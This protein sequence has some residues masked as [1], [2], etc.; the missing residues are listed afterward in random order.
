[1]KIHHAIADGIAATHMLAGL[2]DN[3]EGNT[4]ANQI[5]AAKEPATRLRLP[6]ITLN[7]INWIAGAWRTSL[8]LGS[9]AAQALHG[10]IEIVGGLLRPAATSSLTGPVTS[11]R[12]YASAE[13]SLEDVMRVCEKFDVTIND[14]ALAAITDSFRAML[15]RRG[16]QPKANS[17][18]T[19]VPVSVRSNDA[20]DE[21]D[22][23]VSAMLP[24]LPVEKADPLEQLRTVHRRL[25]RTKASGQRQ[26]GST[27][28]A[29]S[30][31]IPFAFSAWTLRALSHLP[32]R[33]VVTVTTNVPG[34]RHRL[35]VMDR[36][37]IRLLPIPPI[38]LGL[39]TA[40]AILS[41]AEHLVFGITADYDT[42]P[43]IDE[44]AEGIQ[45][46]VSRL[47]TLCTADDT[48]K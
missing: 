18:R 5:R 8:S 2:S 38:A 46:G 39:R 30:N 29:A 19:L 44:L 16:H 41:Y 27:L 47:A 20:L 22:N 3:G 25:A 26:A 43:D 36:E 7:P 28:V 23:R 48:P 17:V 4:Y 10:G 24:Y 21:T 12:R 35:R 15:V 1:M 34:P 14:V 31:M 42:A 13:V 6:T 32:Q 33:G 45:R 9:A 11:M 40:I 37:V